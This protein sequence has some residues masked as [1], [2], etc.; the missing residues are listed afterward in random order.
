[1]VSLIGGLSA[2]LGL[3]TFGALLS[4]IGPSIDVLLSGLAIGVVG[5]SMLLLMR[6]ADP[7]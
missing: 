3:L 1:M 6:R 4:L 2:P 5:T 7:Q